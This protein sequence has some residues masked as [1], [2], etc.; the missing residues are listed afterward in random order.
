MSVIFTVIFLILYGSHIF[1]QTVNPGNNHINQHSDIFYTGKEDSLQSLDVYW[2]PG[3]KNARVL[4]F[5]HGGGW[6]SEDKKL[7]RE[8]ASYLADNGVTVVVV[9]Y[10]LSPAVKFPSHAEDVAAAVY[11]T[12]MFINKYN[13]DKQN[14]YLMGH[15][16]G[17]H[18]ITLILCDKK[19]LEKYKMAPKDIAGAVTI[20]G[21]FEIKTQEGGATK[22]FLGMVFGDDETVWQEA[23]CKNHI[24]QKSKN[25]VPQFLISWSKKD[26]PLIVNENKNIIAEFKKAEM[27]FRTFL[28]DGNNHYAFK[29]D[30]KNNESAFFE[31]LMQFME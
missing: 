17:A 12:Y 7:Y 5:V 28:F 11:W 2:K 21:V 9:N 19:Y 10:R 20:N 13:G 31:K 14:I 1:S 24:N 15:S 26:D 22:K 29:N 4:V 6:L 25:S 23:S 27:D 8:M 30:L 3:A 16:A 18:L